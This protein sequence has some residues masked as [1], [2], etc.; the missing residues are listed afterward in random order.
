MMGKDID[1]KLV[2]RLADIQAKSFDDLERRL[3]V[4][5][6]LCGDHVTIADILACC[7]LESMKFVPGH[8]ELF[9]QKYPRTADWLFRMV[10]LNPVV[11]EASRKSRQLADTV[12]N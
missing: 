7:E 12:K 11:L 8:P 3:T 10:D 2:K 5:K 6:Y 1:V 4:H 9:A